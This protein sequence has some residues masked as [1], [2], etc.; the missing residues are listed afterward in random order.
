MSWDGEQHTKFTYK[1][2]PNMKKTI[3]WTWVTSRFF[4]VK[5][6]ELFGHDPRK[7][8]IFFLSAYNLFYYFRVCCTFSFVLMY[9]LFEV[10]FIFLNDV[11]F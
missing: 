6:E 4:T 2:I 9:F 5:Y 1:D 11:S 7:C 3:L 10:F 8:F